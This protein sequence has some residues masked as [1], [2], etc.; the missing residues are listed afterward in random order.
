MNLTEDQYFTMI[1]LGMIMI[2]ISLAGFAWAIWPDAFV[3]LVDLVWELLTTPFR[4]R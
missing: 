1:Y 4:Y 3:D 2:G